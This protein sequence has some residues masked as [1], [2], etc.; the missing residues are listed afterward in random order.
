MP[1]LPVDELLA[2][3][4]QIGGAVSSAPPPRLAPLPERRPLVHAPALESSRPRAAVETPSTAPVREQ[5]ESAP[6][7]AGAVGDLWPDFV[8]S[9]RSSKPMLA[10]MLEK[11]RP[12]KIDAA[13][14]EIGYGQ[15]AFE[16]ERLKDVAV[17]TELKSLLKQFF[18]QE[19]TVLVREVR[20]G[21]AETPSLKEKKTHDAE[22]RTR[23]L[24]TAALAHPVIGEALQVFGAELKSVSE[25][26][27]P[28]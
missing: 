18:G 13:N 4:A 21:D 9:V 23:T 6:V 5:H 8:A 12:F 16:L 1:L 22:E 20:T 17:M 14:V 27:G 26:E 2:R 24:R 15:G 11:A 3:L 19:P 10:V 25:P 28:V 7:R